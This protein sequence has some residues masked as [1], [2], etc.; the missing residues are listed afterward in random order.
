MTL[1]FTS[2][3]YRLPAS[4]AMSDWCLTKEW[5]TDGVSRWKYTAALGVNM[6]TKTSISYFFDLITKSNCKLSNHYITVIKMVLYS[7]C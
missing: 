7:R 2:I 5:E 6:V 4:H 1:D 3:T